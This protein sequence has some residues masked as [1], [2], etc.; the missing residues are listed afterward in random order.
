MLRE[1]VLRLPHMPDL[2]SF[3]VLCS[4]DAEVDFFNNI[5]H[6]QVSSLCPIGLF[7]ISLVEFQSKVLCITLL[8]P[9]T[10]FAFF[11][12]VT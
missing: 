8:V 7:S 9:L 11:I 2:N 4:E 5:T 6:L 1:M 3:K 10:N 12:A